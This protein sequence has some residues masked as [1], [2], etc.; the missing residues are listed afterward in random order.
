[1]PN[2]AKQSR[3]QEKA[4]Q[5]KSSRVRCWGVAV[6]H[7]FLPPLASIVYASKTG[8]WAPT[9]VATGV[10]VVGI[11]LAI[12]DMGITACIAAPLTSAAMI[13]N[14][15]KDDRRRQKFIGPE[16]ADAI[17]FAKSF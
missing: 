1:M 10:G 12:V 15:V 4:R 13:I 3:R 16:E 7:F 8:R 17:F 2:Q 6:S 11:P 5:V 14:Q 9:I